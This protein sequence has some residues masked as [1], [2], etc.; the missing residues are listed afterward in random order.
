VEI[1]AGIG[2]AEWLPRLVAAIREDEDVGVARI[3]ELVDDVRLGPAEAAG[4]GEELRGLERL[5]LH[6]QQRAD[7]PRL[8]EVADGGGV[9]RAEIDAFDRE[10]QRIGKLAS[11]HLRK[12][13]EMRRGITSGIS[14]QMMIAAST[15]SIGISMMTVSLSAKRSRTFAIAQATRRQS[16]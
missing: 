7:E 10:A 4:E 12:S 5:A 2:E 13:G 14:G 16:P 11:D 15:S 9:E 1:A 8:L 6:D 3:V